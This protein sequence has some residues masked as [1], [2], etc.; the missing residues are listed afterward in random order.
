M[1]PIG[2][3]ISVVSLVGVFKECV[4][5]FSLISATSSLGNDFEILNAKLDVEKTLLLQWAQRVRLLQPGY[6]ER[7]N[8]RRTAKAVSTTLSALRSLL[9]K[10]EDLQRKY[11]LKLDREIDSSRGD[12]ISS[13]GKGIRSALVGTTT[14][15]VGPQITPIISGPRMKQFLKDFDAFNRRVKATQKQASLKKRLLWVVRDREAFSLW[16]QQISDFVGRLNEVIPPRQDS[17]AAVAQLVHDIEQINSI[18]G[19]HLVLSAAQEIDDT[20]ADSAERYMERR[21]IQI[22]RE[23]QWRILDCLYFSTINDR[24]C[25][26]VSTY[27]TLC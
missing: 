13:I 9:S 27:E 14:T 22:A 10:T 19:V 8:Q 1:E 18:G 20:T 16:I 3:A 5:L 25:G 15:V 2:F 24:E 7:L 26:L 11:G 6:D 23:C 21:R 12:S 17:D 4:D